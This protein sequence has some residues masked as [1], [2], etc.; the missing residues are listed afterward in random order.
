MSTT[1]EPNT[2]TKETEKEG[3]EAAGSKAIGCWGCFTGAIGGAMLTELAVYLWQRIRLPNGQEGWEVLH[4][5]YWL[6]L[7]LILGALIGYILSVSRGE[8]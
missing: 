5:I 1:R 4:Y 7:G 8:K 2:V 3:K 6:P